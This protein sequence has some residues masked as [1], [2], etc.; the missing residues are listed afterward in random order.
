VLAPRGPWPCGAFCWG[1]LAGLSGISR[2][3]CKGVP[4]ARCEHKRETSHLRRAPPIYPSPQAGPCR[5]SQDGH[6]RKRQVLPGKKHYRFKRDLNEV[7]PEQRGRGRTKLRRG[8]NVARPGCTGNSRR[9]GQ[10]PRGFRRDSD[11]VP[12]K[13]GICDAS[14]RLPWWIKDWRAVER[15]SQTSVSPVGPALLVPENRPASGAGGGPVQ[16]LGPLDPPN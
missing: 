6:A 14:V 7:M 15:D 9:R 2:P 5:D 10:I 11:G 1:S 16:W 13:S 8:K 12:T 3:G 4:P